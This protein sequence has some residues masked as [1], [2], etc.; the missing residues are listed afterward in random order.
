MGTKSRGGFLTSAVLVWGRFWHVL[1]ASDSR[2]NKQAFHRPRDG[3]VEGKYLD[4]TLT[5]VSTPTNLWRK[6]R[7]SIKGRKMLKPHLK[8]H[9]WSERAPEVIIYSAERDEQRERW[10]EQRARLV[11][12]SFNWNKLFYPFSHDSRNKTKND[13][14]LQTLS[15]IDLRH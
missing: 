2:A 1:E 15:C 9:H 8:Q 11:Q 14:S 3:P 12:S 6:T 5:T 13:F 4:L 10:A 7:A